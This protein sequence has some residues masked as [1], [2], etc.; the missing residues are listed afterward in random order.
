M[1]HVSYILEKEW[2][3]NGAMLGT[4]LLLIYDFRDIF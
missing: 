1:A 3:I 4:K 2:G